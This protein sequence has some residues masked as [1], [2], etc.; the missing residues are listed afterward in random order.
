VLGIFVLALPLAVLGALMAWLI[1]Y[2]ELTRHYPSRRA[3]A[4]EATRRALAALAFFVILGA[5]IAAILAS[6]H[7]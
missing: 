5:V 6:V 2:D 3:A 1:S 4:L 7:S